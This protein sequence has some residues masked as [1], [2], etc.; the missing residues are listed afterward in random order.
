[1]IQPDHPSFRQAGAAPR[2]RRV[3]RC[4]LALVSAAWAV[5][6]CKVNRPASAQRRPVAKVLGI[7]GLFFK[8]RDPEALRKWYGD[9][10][11]VEPTEWGGTW[12]P[13]DA[14]AAQAGA[15]RDGFVSLLL[16]AVASPLNGHEYARRVSELA[17][18]RECAKISAYCVQPH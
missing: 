14:F 11:G 13:A 4:C 7:G 10:L 8:A 17:G 1:M 6:A 15:A 12:F 3:W 5:K 16:E 18:L 2:H 9:V